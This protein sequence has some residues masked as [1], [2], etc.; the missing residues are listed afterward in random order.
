M[1]DRVLKEI[2]KL[3]EAVVRA[4]VHGDGSY[5]VTTTG[6]ADATRAAGEA[7]RARREQ[8]RRPGQAHRAPGPQGS[9]RRARRGH[10]QG[11]RGVGR[12]PAHRPLRRPQ[13]RR[14]RR[15]ALRALPDRPREG[16]GLRAQ[17][18]E[19]LDGAQPHR[20]AAH[21]RAVAGL[22]RAHG[23]R[24]PQRARRR[25][26]RAARRPPAP[27]SAR[28][29][30]A[31]A[32]STP[33]SASSPAP[34]RRSPRRRAPG[35]GVRRRPGVQTSATTSAS[36]RIDALG[37]RARPRGS[38][39]P[40]PPR[41]SSRRPAPRS[42]RATPPA[43]APP[44]D[45]ALAGRAVEHHEHAGAAGDLARFA[46]GVARGPGD[47]RRRARRS[48]RRTVAVVRRT[49]CSTRRRAAA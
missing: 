32:C 1:L 22:R 6:A 42:A 19:P 10:G 45:G 21:E 40:R 3:T 37:D 29:R 33:P 11:R 25:G 39:R 43:A 47:A 46:A 16:R 49:R 27:T 30:T 20:H 17:A 38:P 26:R 4:D 35:P 34:D 31:R 8:G 24:D 48:P 23:R 7:T 44:V 18:R 9:G 5:D 12:G 41:A 2:P 14:D 36:C 13:R 15:Q 28:T